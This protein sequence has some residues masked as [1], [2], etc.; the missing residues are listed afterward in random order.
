LARPHHKDA[1]CSR[2]P[3]VG[4]KPYVKVL[5]TTSGF[6]FHVHSS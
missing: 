4:L 2:K 6:P 5:K 3:G 1:S